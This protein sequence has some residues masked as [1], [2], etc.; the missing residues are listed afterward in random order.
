[1]AEVFKDV[2]HHSIAYSAVGSG[3]PIV[4]IHAFPTDKELWLPQQAG[5]QKYFHIIAI[6]LWGFGGSSLLPKK[7]IGMTDYADEVNELLDHLH[8]QKA[9]IGGESMGGYVSLAFLEKYPEKVNGLILSDTESIADTE[10]NKHEAMAADV[11]KTGTGPLI[12]EFMPETLTPNVSKTTYEFLEN[13]MKRQSRYAMAAALRGIAERKDRSD[14]LAK[15]T[16]PILILTGDSD[17]VIPPVQSKNMH[18]L[19]KNS[20]LIIIKNSGLTLYSLTI[21][22]LHINPAPELNKGSFQPRHNRRSG[23]TP[24]LPSNLTH[25]ELGLITLTPIT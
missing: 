1:M 18:K 7:T 10:K 13:I 16:L 20:K 9:I 14:V 4:L 12:K 15:T 22:Y 11:L 8:I 24:S 6:D 23:Q 19:A 5:L 3:E 17:V 25:T 21:N 2:H